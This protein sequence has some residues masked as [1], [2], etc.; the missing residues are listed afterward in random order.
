MEETL[1]K[2]FG[3]KVEETLLNTNDR[4]MDHETGL[5]DEMGML[6]VGLEDKMRVLDV[7]LEDEMRVL[8]VDLEDEIKVLAV[9]LENKMRVLA[10]GLKS[11]AWINYGGRRLY[12]YNDDDF[13]LY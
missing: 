1:I 10:V 2:L 12:Q 5:A 9:G 6:A 11:K 7:G 3:R 4:S 13:L 8:T